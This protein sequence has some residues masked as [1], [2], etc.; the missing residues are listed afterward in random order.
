MID[1]QD[2]PAAGSLTVPSC[3]AADTLM[4]DAVDRQRLAR[5]CL[6]FLMKLQ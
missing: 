2:A 4:R 6:G 3:G 1:A 5:L